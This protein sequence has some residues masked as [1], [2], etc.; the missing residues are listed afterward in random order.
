MARRMGISVRTCRSH[1]ARLMQTLGGGGRHEQN[2]PHRPRPGGRR[3][4]NAPPP[5]RPG[6]TLRAGSAA[7]HRRAPAGRRH[8]GRSRPRPVP[9][10]AR[11][12]PPRPARPR[13]TAARTGGRRPGGTPRAPHPRHPRPGGRVGRPR[14]GAGAA[15]P[16]HRLLRRPG[17]DG[18]PGE[19]R[20]PG[21]R[22]GG[23]KGGP[24]AHPDPAPRQQAPRRHARTGPAER[25][26][27]PSARGVHAPPVPALRAL[28]HEPEAVRGPAA[29]RGPADPHHGADR[30]A[31]VRLRPVR[32]HLD[33]ARTRCRAV[34]HPPGPRPLSRPRLRRP[35]GGRH[36][37]RRAAADIVAGR[38]R[39]RR[40]A[41]H[42]PPPRRRPRRRRH[43]PQDGHQRP[44]LPLPH[45]QTHADPR[46]TT[47]PHL[48]ALLIGSGIVEAHRRD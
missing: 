7:L 43:R 44:H 6:G 11:A 20:H 19:A 21:R 5:P 28:Q 22:R 27:A 12:A 42:R 33:L 41:Q 13:Q 29:P 34:R 23:G 25:H 45:R 30:G 9:R 15:R 14:R 38:P 39:H 32:L 40:P 46:A 31:D 24:E 10:P 37:L 2:A 48:G 1:I 36:A 35:V 47:R 18:D 3:E 26:R 16:A 17:R 8:R 4:R